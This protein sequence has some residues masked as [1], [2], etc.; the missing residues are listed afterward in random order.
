MAAKVDSATVQD[1][2]QLYHHAF[3][4]RGRTLVSTVRVRGPSSQRCLVA[5]LRGRHPHEA[6]CFDETVPTLNLVA[7]EHESGDGPRRG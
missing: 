6:I 3:F 1:G 5:S 7:A 4:F 2:Y